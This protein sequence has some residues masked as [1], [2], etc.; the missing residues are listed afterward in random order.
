MPKITITLVSWYSFK[1]IEKLIRNLNSKAA[2]PES[3]KYLIIDNSNGSDQPPGILNELRTSIQIIPFSPGKLKGSRA[4]AAGLNEAMKHLNT[5]YTLVCDPD[6]HIFKSQW[7]TCLINYLS[8]HNAVAIGAPYP[9][10]KTGKYHDFPSPPF[11]FFETQTIKEIC[12]DWSPFSDTTA[13][14]FWKFFIRQIGRIGLLISRD[15]Y[16]KYISIRHYSHWAEKTL[17]IFAPDTGWR[18]A[19]AVRQQKVSSIVFDAI[20]PDSLLVKNVKYSQTFNYLAKHYELFFFEGEPFVAH[21]YGTRGILW[22]TKYG[23][24][25]TYWKECLRA[26]EQ[27]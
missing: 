10:W 24:D 6:I 25:D 19:H 20:M 7:D 8:K 16:Q 23:N 27:E 22:R 2:Y 9:E 21:K 18:I 14:F 5:P 4:H 1:Y 13:G 12:D 3:L 11:C 26:I 17:G 15:R